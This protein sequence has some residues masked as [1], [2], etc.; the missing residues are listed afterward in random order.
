MRDQS[1]YNNKVNRHLL[2]S[3]LTHN[4]SR[5]TAVRLAGAEAVVNI[6]VVNLRSELKQH[7]HS[8]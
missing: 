8:M 6:F 1:C 2:P 4:N 5:Q 3:T 7:I